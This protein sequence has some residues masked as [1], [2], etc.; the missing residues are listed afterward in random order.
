MKV[1]NYGL[2]KNPTGF[3][4]LWGLDF[5]NLTPINT[6]I[7]FVPRNLSR[8]GIGTTHNLKDFIGNGSLTC[9][10]VL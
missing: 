10:V 2:T 6:Q 1:I 4:N 3:E 8:Q 7:E 5:L 9:F